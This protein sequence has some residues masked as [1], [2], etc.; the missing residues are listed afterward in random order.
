[1]T[2]S[3]WTKA[4][5][6]LIN[7]PWGLWLTQTR[8][9]PLDRWLK[10]LGGYHPARKH[11]QQADRRPQVAAMMFSAM[12]FL[13]L[14][15]AL[16]HSYR[17]QTLPDWA[18]WDTSWELDSTVKVP[19][20]AF[21]YWIALRNQSAD[22]SPRPLRDAD[23]RRKWFATVEAALDET[24]LS[25][26][27]LAWHGLRP[28]WLPLLQERQKA[29]QWTETDLRKFIELQHQV[30]PLWLRPQRDQDHAALAKTLSDAGVRVRLEGEQAL[31]AEGGKGIAA[32]Q[33]YKDGLVEIQD[34]ASQQISATVAAQPGQKVWDACAGAGGKSLAIAALMNNKGVVVATD[35]HAYK[36]DEVKRRA[37]RAQLFNVRTF[38]WAGDAPLRLPKEVA[39]QQG[40][41]WVLVDAPCSSTG[42]W[43]RNPDARWRFSAEDTAEL[44]VLQQQILD[45]AAPA[46]RLGGHLVYATCSWQV[47]EN[48][49]Q[50]EAFLTRNP[51]FE[52]VSQ[53]LLGAPQMNSDTMFAAVVIRK[54]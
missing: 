9:Q 22:D 53:T 31:C 47:C 45:N 1:M 21:W 35:L 16:E 40:F 46:V 44:L 4:D 36:L 43:R 51:G 10:Q 50:V 5:Y 52:L 33:A 13:H 27:W 15:A 26:S 38:P 28:Q 18:E 37:K 14:A 48:E 19:P 29:S 54:A 39:Q 12:R 30:P 11:L 25:P 32:T 8:W 17:T 20:A 34:L 42:T 41:D 24:T 2:I 6:D 23:A 7:E 3:P 49:A